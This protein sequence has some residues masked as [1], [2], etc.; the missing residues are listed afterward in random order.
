MGE[1]SCLIGKLYWGRYQCPMTVDR[2]QW[3]RQ[4]YEL[5]HWTCPTCGKGHLR[6]VPETFHQQETG[7]SK[8]AHSLDDWEPDWITR[9]FAGIMK[10]SLA[11]CE[12]L[13]SICGT[14]HLDLV[15]Y[16]DQEYGWSRDDKDSFIVRTLHPAPIPIALPKK[17]PDPICDTITTASELI[18]TSAEATGNQ[19]R[20]AVELF[21][22]DVGI[23]A[24]N[25][26]GDRLSTHARIKKFEKQDQ[27]NGEV[28]LATKWLGNS[29]SHPGGLTRDDV[30]DA[31][32]MLEYVLENHYGTTKKSLLAKVAAINAQK[33]PVK[34][35][36]S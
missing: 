23:P 36:K 14:G 22:D 35:K 26:K 27:E 24:T 8:A 4:F 31:F 12:E 25:A 34:K 13:V 29:G 16:H 5:P 9:R 32:D 19:L 28:L 20:Q 7:P 17:T 15:E 2:S 1:I 6:L 18:W 21:L 33:G 10:C 30:L 3:K 11:A